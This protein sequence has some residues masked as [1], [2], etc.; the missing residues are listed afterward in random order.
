MQSHV[1]WWM[2]DPGRLIGVQKGK[3]S[4][5]NYLLEGVEFPTIL[6]EDFTL[7]LTVEMEVIFSFFLNCSKGI[8]E[9][10]CETSCSEAYILWKHSMAFRTS[11]CISPFFES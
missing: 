5:G 10:F 8:I 2:V 9:T 11:N 7:P 4:L 1:T 6:P 3:G